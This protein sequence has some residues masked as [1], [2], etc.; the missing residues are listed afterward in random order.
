MS[1]EFTQRVVELARRAGS[2]VQLVHLQLSAEGQ[3]AR[4]ANEDRARFGKLRDAGLLARLQT[5]FEA[6]E[7][8][9]PPADLVID[10]ERVSAEAAAGMIA[11]RLD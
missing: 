9:M 1:P 2:E 8:A 11:A 7:R 5:E 6:C 3:M 4:I 10:S